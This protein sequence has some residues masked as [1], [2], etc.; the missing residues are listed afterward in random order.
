MTK[1][2]VLTWLPIG[3][4]VAEGKLKTEYLAQSQ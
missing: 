2:Y 1:V 4:F 3:C